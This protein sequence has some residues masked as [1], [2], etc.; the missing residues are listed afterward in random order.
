MENVGFGC[1][2][3]Q[4]KLLTEVGNGKGFKFSMDADAFAYGG[5][6]GGRS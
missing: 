4:E 2:G 3:V 5:R 1:A 6:E